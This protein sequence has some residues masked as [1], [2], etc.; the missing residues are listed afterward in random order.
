MTEDGLLL[1]QGKS[2]RVSVRVAAEFL[3]AEQPRTGHWSKQA[4]SISITPGQDLLLHC[5]PQH[6]WGGRFTATCPAAARSHMAL[7]DD[8]FSDSGI[9]STLGEHRSQAL[10]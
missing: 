1:Q 10:L 9:L 8:H 2:Q 4:Y 6:T 7:Y 3:S 5:Q